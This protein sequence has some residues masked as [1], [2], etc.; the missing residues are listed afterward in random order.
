MRLKGLTCGH[1]QS[2]AQ[3][4]ERAGSQQVLAVNAGKKRDFQL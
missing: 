1:E 2:G 4:W 3:S